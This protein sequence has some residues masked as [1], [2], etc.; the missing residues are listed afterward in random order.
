MIARILSAAITQLL[1]YYS[2]IYLGGPRQ[3][4]KTTLLR[5]AFPQLPYANMEDEEKRLLAESDPKRF[6]KQFPQGG[7]LDEAQRVPILFSALQVLTDEDQSRRFLL[8]G[9]QNFLLMERI[10][11]SLAGRVG[12]LNLWPLSWAELQHTAYAPASLEEWVWKGG[13]PGLYD[14][15]TPKSIFFNNYV[16]TYLERDVRS[17][18]NVGDLSLFV[19]FMRL[20][21]GRVGQPLNITGLANDLGLAVNTVKGWLSVLEA[22]YII[23]YVQPYFE[24]FNKRIIKSPK[25]YF[26]DTGLLSHLLRIE[27]PQQL[28]SHHY[29]GHLVENA[30]VA[31][32]YKK[33]LNGGERPSFWFWQDQHGHEV[34]LLI[35]EGGSLTAIQIKSAQTYNP[36]MLQGLLKWQQLYPTTP[37]RTVLL[38]AG[39]EALQMEKA[40]LLPWHRVGS[41]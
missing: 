22:S 10:T 17:L 18:R 37:E 3:A 21:A 8:S 28:E 11:Q 35:E 7:I 15:N 16:E 20:C 40:Q 24:N 6:L 9:S 27:T 41:L 23:F 13:Y 25:L 29:F 33:R 19:R 4:G 30:L 26:S 32:L 12:I 38:Y 2:L 5:N 39:E 31:E 36:H 34:D 14:R 1:P